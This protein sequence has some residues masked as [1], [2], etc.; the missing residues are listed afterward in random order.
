MNAHVGQAKPQG[1]RGN[2]AA[3]PA[4]HHFLSSPD[5][6]RDLRDLQS[7]LNISTG[8]H[9]AES[10]DKAGLL[11]VIWLTPHGIDRLQRIL[12]G[13]MHAR[14]QGGPFHPPCSSPRAARRVST[15]AFHDGRQ[16]KACTAASQNSST[17]SASPRAGRSS[18]YSSSR[19]CQSTIVKPRGAQ[20]LPVMA[21]GP[22]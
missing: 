7:G 22:R 16:G 11:P 20:T 1:C 14:L 2:P 13:T 15:P 6:P 8:S 18:R 21:F 5:R 3:R 9:R 12:E 19:R 4:G 10:T 17:V